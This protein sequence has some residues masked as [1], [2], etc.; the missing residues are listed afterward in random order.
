MPKTERLTLRNRT[1][2][3]WR[4]STIELSSADHRFHV[5]VNGT[6]INSMTE[7]AI[8]L[9]Y[10]KEHVMSVVKEQRG[11]ASWNP[12]RQFAVTLTLRFCPKLHGGHQKLDVENFVKPIVDAL[13]AG[14]FCA[15]ET[16]PAEIKRF[17][18][19]DSNFNTLFIHRLPDTTYRDQEGVAINVSAM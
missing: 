1:I 14:L 9:R 13:A 16:D 17:D 4:V 19:N 2:G 12:D 5:Y 15:P 18:Y 6:I 11:E 7:N 8:A 3:S 10:W